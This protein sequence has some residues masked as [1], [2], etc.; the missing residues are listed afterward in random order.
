MSHIYPDII[1]TER[2]VQIRNLSQH[3]DTEY[4]YGADYTFEANIDGEW[5]P[6]AEPQENWSFIVIKGDRRCQQLDVAVGWWELDR[7]WSVLSREK[8]AELPHADL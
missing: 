5:W 3:C 4:P 2:G 6:C 7:I 8:V 1:R